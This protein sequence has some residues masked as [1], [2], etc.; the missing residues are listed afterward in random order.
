MTKINENLVSFEQIGELSD[1]VYFVYDLSSAILRYINAA[2]VSVLQL[3]PEA[4]KN[5]P[6]LIFDVLHPE[7]RTYV[8]DF[9]KQSVESSKPGKI[10][11]RMLLPDNTKKY[12]ELKIYP[13]ERTAKRALIAGIAV[14]I[15]TTKS[16]ILYG[17]KINARKN[18][19][20]EILAHDLK[21]PIGMINMMATAIQNLSR[22]KGEDTIIRYVD[23]IQSLCV[24]NIDLIRDLVN[25]E[26]LESTEVDL[27]KERADIVWGLSDIIEQYKKSEDIILKKFNFTTSTAKLYIDM[28]S[29]KLMQVFNNLISNAIKF[30]P[31]NGVIS[32][33]ILEKD[34]TV[35]VTVSDNGIGIP[36]EFHPYLFDK[37]TRARRKGL[38]GEDAVGLGMSLIKTIVELHK[39]SIWFES[40]KDQG[41]TFYIEVPK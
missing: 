37:F 11:F 19:I 5:K 34:D 41:S 36:E 29:L 18:S 25:Q 2:S 38:K 24:R 32:I 27:R 14:D 9:L 16:N 20:L 10:E 33:D 12:I 28:D 26:F 40:A 23:L 17:E 7:D 22:K 3:S 21:A 1:D 13:L 31:E 4:V 30:T 8:L 39:G 6:D 15:T 35:L